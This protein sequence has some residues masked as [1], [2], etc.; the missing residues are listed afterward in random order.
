[1]KELLQKMLFQTHFLW[2]KNRALGYP[3]LRIAITYYCNND[4]A[5]CS[6]QSIKDEREYMQFSDFVRILEWLKKQNKKWIVITGGEPLTHPDIYT[7]L[8]YA[9]ANGIGCHVQT[10]GLLIDERFAAF[11]KGKLVYLIVNVNLNNT[12]AQVKEKVQ[13]IKN[14]VIL[15]RYNISKEGV[16]RAELFQLA[17]CCHVPIRFGHTV[18]SQDKKNEHFTQE[19]VFLLKKEYSKFLAEARLCG[20]KVHLARPVP[21]CMYEKKEWKK[22]VRQNG[23]KSRCLIGDQENYASRAIVNPD[24]S[25]YVCYGGFFKAPSLLDFETLN[26]VSSY[27]KGSIEGLRSEPLI[28]KCKTCSSFKDSTCQG[29]CLVYKN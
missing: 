6:Y 27:F 18:P 29:G 21:E 28:E 22:L 3:D 25:V 8:D 13:L 19:D 14:K 24:M 16:T 2:C 9:H 4:C 26:N 1:M 17:R 15:F 12:F 11:I 10:N 23:F 7:M 20:V 5:Y